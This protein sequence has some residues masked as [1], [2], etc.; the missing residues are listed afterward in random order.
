MKVTFGSICQIVSMKLII[1]EVYVKLI[2]F[3]GP[4]CQTE[5]MKLIIF[6]VYSTTSSTLVQSVK[7]TNGITLNRVFH[8]SICQ[9][10]LIKICLNTFQI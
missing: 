6:E 4:I 2:N 5:Q 9:I 3:I 8:W 1:F 7:L 10:E